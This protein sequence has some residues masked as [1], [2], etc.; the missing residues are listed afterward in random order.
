M[1]GGGKGWGGNE[2]P[3]EEKVRTFSIYSLFPNVSNLAGGF[4]NLPFS[5]RTWCYLKI[6]F[7]NNLSFI[8]LFYLS[9][10]FVYRIILTYIW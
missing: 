7:E 1:E 8:I 10:I 6:F 2:G 5:N 9:F 4:L 3:G